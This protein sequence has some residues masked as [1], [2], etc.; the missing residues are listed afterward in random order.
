MLNGFYTIA[1][2]MLAQQRHLGLIGNN[3]VNME[4]PGFRGERMVFTTF[5]H[6]LMVRKEAYSR[7][8]IGSASPITLV[9]DV[10][11]TGNSGV[12][13]QTDH[14]F[15]L[16]LDGPGYLAVT[17]NEGQL[18]LTRNGQ[19]DMDTEGY[20]ILPGVGRVQGMDGPLQIRDAGFTVLPDGTVNSSAGR[21]LGTLRVVSPPAD[22]RLT[23]L[24]N[25]MY[26][27]PDGTEPET[28][29]GFQL[30]QGTRESSNVDYNREMASFIEA[31][32]AFQSCSSALQIIDNMNRRSAGQIAAV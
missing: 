19:L 29:V 4:T 31:Q 21:R 5:Q 22:T 11:T 13:R 1:S 12:Y 30:L 3:L 27:L 26:Q 15:D 2:G 32:R 16:A 20:L 25:G 6:E 23:H 14:P 10:I 24:S 28:A 18:Y 7:T 8:P 17:G 9:D